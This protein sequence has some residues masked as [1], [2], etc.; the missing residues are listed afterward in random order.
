M[1]VARLSSALRRRSPSRRRGDAKGQGG[2]AGQAVPARPV[3]PLDAPSRPWRLAPWMAKDGD[4]L[5]SVMDAWYNGVSQADAAD[6]APEPRAAEAVPPAAPPPMAVAV[7][8]AP[9]P[10]PA[11]PSDADA[12][13]GRAERLEL[14][15]PE[16]WPSAAVPA[17]VARAVLACCRGRP[18]MVAGLPLPVF[19]HHMLRVGKA[20]DPAQG[21]ERIL[22]FRRKYN[23]PLTICLRDISE[24]VGGS[25]ALEYVPPRESAGQPTVV[26][27]P[28]HL[29][30]AKRSME[31]YQMLLMFMLEAAFRESVERREEGFGLVVIIDLREISSALTRHVLMSFSDVARG[32]AMCSGSLPMSIAHVHLVEGSSNGGVIKAVV[33]MFMAPLSSKVL[34]RIS[35]RSHEALL[36]AVGP[37]RLPAS[38]GGARNAGQAEWRGCL[39]A[40]GKQEAALGLASAAC[41]APPES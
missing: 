9:P 40:W 19:W 8:A 39:E 2:L 22:N 6:G 25:A 32:V 23:W 17:D 26:F 7:P 38:L 4:F 29:N 36:G 3:E 37:D 28:R 14:P 18:P 30:L 10:G 1:A 21:M 5:A 34:S 13:P 24:M 12:D 16:R 31:P 15:G 41:T 11:V 33:S 35:W 27:A 20:S